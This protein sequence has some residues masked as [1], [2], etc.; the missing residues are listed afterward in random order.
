VSHLL[1]DVLL[2]FNYGMLAYFVMLNAIYTLLL[3][4][5]W[6]SIRTYVH[7]RRLIDYDE[8]ARSPLTIPISIIVPAYNEATVIVDSVR[9]L[10]VAHF[11]ALEVVV[12]S[13]GS[14]DDTVQALTEAFALVSASR[15]PVARLETAEIRDI[16]V[17]ANDDR[18]V[19]IDKANG[20]KADAINAG[21][22]YARY[23]LFC[24]LDADTLIDDDALLRLVRPF[25]V[26][27]DTIAC[28]GIVRVVNGCSVE[29]SRVVN[30]EM[31]R[32]MIENVQVVE[33]L[34]AFL[35]GRTGWARLGAL[36]VISGA[37]GVFRRDLAVEIGGYDTA[38]V[39][40]DAEFVVRLHRHCREND[41]PYR[42]SFL[43]DP[44]C[45]TE[46][47]RSMRSLCRQRNRWHRGLIETLLRH[48]GMIGRRRYGVVGL[49]A[50]PYFVLFEA[51]GPLIETIGYC[52][53]ALSLAFG[54]LDTSVALTL[55]ILSF[56]YGLVLSFGAL[57]VEEHAFRR[58]RRWPDVGRLALA[59]VVENFGFRQIGSFVRAWAF[60][61]LVRRPSNTWGEMHRTG[62]APPQPSASALPLESLSEYALG[63]PEPPVPDLIEEQAA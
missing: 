50:M 59:A 11:P 4:L 20:G 26:E 44:V 57:I 49:F 42:V 33:Y 43:A 51:L 37:F 60:V 53:V 6:K 25:Q 48:R 8:I 39:G 2:G 7:R 19:V 9:S 31:P 55:L 24:T 29:R 22:C 13:D 34:R 45:W 3:V 52:V 5:G 40:E 54:V 16:L 47:P 18:L 58:Y 38:T 1:R 23:P 14:K 61:T 63:R 30:V 46:V 35:A 28:G 15:V 21:L 27:P 10:L 12:I 41:I 56:T 17:S 62:F 36:L 32:R